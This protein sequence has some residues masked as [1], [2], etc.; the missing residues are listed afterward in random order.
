MCRRGDLKRIN[1]SNPV[2]MGLNLEAFEF[3]FS[4]GKQQSF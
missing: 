4:A 2:Y 3:I 1:C